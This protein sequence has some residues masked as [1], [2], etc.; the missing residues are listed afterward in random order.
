[1]LFRIAYQPCQP[2]LACFPKD[3]DLTKACAVTQ[4]PLA[5][6]GCIVAKVVSKQNYNVRRRIRFYLQVFNVVVKVRRTRT[7]Q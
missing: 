4:V 2:T 5:D 6:Y 3:P 7:D 1:M